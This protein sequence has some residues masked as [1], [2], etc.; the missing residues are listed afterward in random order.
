[1]VTAWRRV[2]RKRR[3]APTGPRVWKGCVAG[4]SGVGLTSDGGVLGCLSLV[5][6]GERFLEGNVR[7]RSLT[8]IWRDPDSFAY[9]PID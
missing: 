1:M 4:L 5:T 6:H 8:E 7:R 3:A 2:R 9:K